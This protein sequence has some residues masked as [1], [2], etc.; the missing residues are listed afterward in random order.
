VN[1]GADTDSAHA[2]VRVLSSAA[3]SPPG[4]HACFRARRELVEPVRE[5]YQPARAW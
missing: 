4:L 5:P 3:T 2:V 1:G